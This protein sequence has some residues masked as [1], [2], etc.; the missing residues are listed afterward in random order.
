MD[1]TDHN[2]LAALDF[3]ADS[4]AA[5]DDAD[6]SDPLDFSVTEV[7]GDDSA[8]DEFLGEYTPAVTETEDAEAELDALA[9]ETDEN[10]EEDVLAPYTFTVTNPPGIVSV[11]A[12]I[13]GRIREVELSPKARSMSEAELADEIIVL[14]D[15]A[16]QRALAGQQTYL[17]ESEFLADGMR[18]FGL[19]SRE[20]VRDFMQNGMG[21]P[22]AEQAEAAQAEVFATRYADDRG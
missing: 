3:S 2:D 4:D 5:S 1:S 13:G 8:M 22:S 20:V 6:A 15:L 21:M 10:G 9:E 12:L 14:A 17:M 18:E 11:S 7:D 19:D 16:R